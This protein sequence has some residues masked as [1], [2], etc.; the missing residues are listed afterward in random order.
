MIRI[1]LTAADIENMRIAETADL[2]TELLLGAGLPTS[3][4]RGRSLAQWQRTVDHRRHPRTSLLSDLYL[5]TTVPGFLGQAVHSDLSATAA[6]TAALAPELVSQYVVRHIAASGALTPFSRALADGESA[7]YFALGRAVADYQAVAI[8]PYQTQINSTVATAV[9]E[10]T[11]RMARSGIGH[12]LRTLHP[13]VSWN[14]SVLAIGTRYEA[15]ME[16]DGKILVLQPTILTTGPVVSEDLPDVMV[17][18]IPTVMAP[19]A[20]HTLSIDRRPLGALLGPARAAA[21]TAIATTPSLTTGQLAD[22]LSLSAAAASRHAAILREAG[23]ITTH[24]NGMTVH[25]TPTPLGRAL[26]SRPGAEPPP[27]QP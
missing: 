25:H 20:A 24:R 1:H 7:A 18:R 14:G 21:L 8:D 17:I 11:A 13:E 9:A 6:A 3:G 4:R 5:P 26:V 22:V 23:L 12:L 27:T 10:L 19:V 16:L 15:D 2:G